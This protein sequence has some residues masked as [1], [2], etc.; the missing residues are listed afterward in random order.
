MVDRRSENKK[1]LTLMCVPSG[2]H[3]GVS[4]LLVTFSLFLSLPVDFMFRVVVDLKQRAQGGNKK[5]Q[6]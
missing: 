3:L 5:I 2:M 4:D 6:E 1:M